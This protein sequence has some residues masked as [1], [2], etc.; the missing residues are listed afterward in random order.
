MY[1]Q[2]HLISLETFYLTLG[3]FRTHVCAIGGWVQTSEVMCLKEGQWNTHMS[4]SKVWRILVSAL[5][6][7]TIGWY[8]AGVY[9]PARA[10]DVSKDQ[11]ALTVVLPP[12]TSLRSATVTDG[13]PDEA[14]ERLRHPA[15]LGAMVFQWMLGA[16]PYS[17][18][19]SPVADPN[20]LRQLHEY[21][22]PPRLH[23]QARHEAITVYPAY[24]LV[25]SLDTGEYRVEYLQNVVCCQVNSNSPAYLRS[26]SLYGWLQS[27]GWS[28]WLN[29]GQVVRDGPSDTRQATRVKNGV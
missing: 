11:D 9:Q 28:G 27:A 12:S 8:L 4:A 20:S 16:T 25:K 7:V 22:G 19:V 2:A 10:A 13:H 1:H 5:L 18:P 14:M 3:R 29:K 26:P 6:F 23:L 24:R 17:A 15:E 21:L